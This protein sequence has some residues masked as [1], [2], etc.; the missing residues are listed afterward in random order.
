MMIKLI[1]V[2]LLSVFLIP[3]IQF[4]HGQAPGSA[5]GSMDTGQSGQAPDIPVKT[6]PNSVNNA[7]NL[8][9]QAEK[10]ITVPDTRYPSNGSLPANNTLTA[11]SGG[12]GTDVQSEAAKYPSNEAPNT[13]NYTNNKVNAANNTLEGTLKKAPEAFGDILNKGVGGILN[14]GNNTS[15]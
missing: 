12:N 7:V 1:S 11:V 9:Q 15:K 4:G 2:L 6:G 3:L 10:G 5:G 13:V 8:A 14:L